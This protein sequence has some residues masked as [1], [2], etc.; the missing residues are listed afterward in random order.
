M[1][2]EPDDFITCRDH[3]MLELFYCSGLRLSELAGLDLAQLDLA[4]GLL[5]V[6][7]KGN[8]VRELPVGR[9]AREAL[10]AW[11]ALRQGVAVD[12]ALFVGRRGRRLGPRAVQLRVHQTGLRELEQHRL[13]SSRNPGAAQELPGHADVGASQIYA[14]LGFQ[15]LARA[16]DQAH[17][18]AHRRT[19][20]DEDDSQ[21]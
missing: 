9:K 12:P 1:P 11:L 19:G 14:P 8:R 3:A 16:Y 2:A 20:R 18:R 13:E 4:A 7:G 5:R 6:C 10:Q 21:D 17:P 15:H